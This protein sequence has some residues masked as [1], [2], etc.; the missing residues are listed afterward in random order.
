MPS[1]CAAKAVGISAAGRLE[2][3]GERDLDRVALVGERHERTGGSCGQLAA[4]L[5]GPVVLVD[6]SADVFR[7]AGLAGVDG[8]GVALERRELAEQVPPAQIDVG[9]R[10]PDRSEAKLGRVAEGD[11]R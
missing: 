3:G 9:L 11:A 4:R 6:R 10:L 2:T 7:L 1:R 5:V 8:A